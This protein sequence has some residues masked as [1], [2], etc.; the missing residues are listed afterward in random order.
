MCLPGAVGVERIE[1]TVEQ[2]LEGVGVAYEVEA[3]EVAGGAGGRE[4]DVVG[5]LAVGH[6]GV[7]QRAGSAAAV[8]VAAARLEGGEA[9]GAAI[10]FLVLPRAAGLVVAQEVVVV[11]G[12]VG[13]IYDALVVLSLVVHGRGDGVPHGGADALQGMHVDDD[14]LGRHGERVGILRAAEGSGTGMVF[15]R[16]RGGAQVEAYRVVAGGVEHIIVL[17]AWGVEGQAADAVLFSD[18]SSV[19]HGDVVAGGNGVGL[20]GVSDGAGVAG[21]ADPRVHIVAFGDGAAAALQA[22]G[23]HRGDVGVGT[24]LQAVQQGRRTTVAPAPDAADVAAVAVHA[25]DGAGEDA[26]PDGCGGVQ[27]VADDAACIVAGDV[28]RGGDKAVL[29]RIGAVGKAHET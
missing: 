10:G 11:G 5:L 26:A 14:I 21:R 13:D 9:C 20:T 12:E 17:E 16:G 25:V 2:Y 6:A 24:I 23:V 7:G 8:D 3:L 1:G 15:C 22:H 18:G 19:G 29:Y 27:S 28:K 4:A